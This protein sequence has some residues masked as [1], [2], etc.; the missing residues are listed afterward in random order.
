MPAKSPRKNP[1]NLY[2]PYDFRRNSGF[3][4]LWPVSPPLLHFCDFPPVMLAFLLFCQWVRQVP[5]PGLLFFASHPLWNIVCSYPYESWTIKK[6]GHPR[7]DAFELWCWRGL[8]RVSWIARRSNQSIL[9]ENSPE[10]LLEGLMLKLKLQYFGHLMQRPDSLEKTLMLG[11]TLR[12]EKKGTTED[13]MVGWHH[14]FNGPES[15]QTP[16]DSEGQG[17]LGCCSS[18]GHKESDTT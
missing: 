15:E 6:A 9:K 4:S 1:R 13:E 10:Y 18:W 11:K 2:Q 8:L 7:I 17:S 12:Q 5:V 3:P 14:Q 16:G